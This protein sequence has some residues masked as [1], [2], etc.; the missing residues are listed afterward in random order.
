M[1]TPES[2]RLL[3]SL[4]ASADPDCPTPAEPGKFVGADLRAESVAESIGEP[5]P[6][7]W[8]ATGRRVRVLRAALP[9]AGLRGANLSGVS[10]EQANL[11]GADLADA[12]LT[13]AVLG[14]ADFSEAL[15]E[16]ADLSGAHLRFALL[17]LAAL[18]GADLQRADLWGAKCREADVDR[19]DFRGAELEEADLREADARECDFRD[20]RLGQT[21]FRD[22]DLRRSDFRGA[23]FR[24][25]KF[26]GADLRLANFESADLSNCTL[27]GVWIS[28]ARLDK[29]RLHAG[30]LGAATGEEL[31][32]DWAGAARGYLTLE[33]NFLQLGDPDAAS[34]A[35]RKRRR[36]AKRRE[37]HAARESYKAR[38]WPRAAEAGYAWASDWLVELVCDYGES[39]ARVFMTYLVLFILF[40]V[41]YAATGSIG[42]ETPVP[43]DPDRRTVTRSVDAV[44]LY[45]MTAMVAPGERPEGLHSTSDGVHMATLIQSTL[46]VFLIGLLGF[47]AGNRI[48]R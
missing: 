31:A 41:G 35:Y 5:P 2:E 4:H 15:L 8:D 26:D 47:V 18:E 19:V 37:G 46:G 13:N 22:A 33:L 48:R 23:M 20:A 43:G 24:A 12:T 29:T 32:G 25:T 36:M 39:V 38:D 3:N 9:G 1:L 44:M 7:W 21:D 28:D 6:P 16:D 30:Q 34:W 14:G 45:S 42:R 17:T 40:A 27:A 10:L 11:K